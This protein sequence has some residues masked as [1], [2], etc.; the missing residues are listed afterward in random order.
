MKITIVI[1]FDRFDDRT[2]SSARCAELTI[3]LTFVVVVVFVVAAALWRCL[4]RSNRSKC[5]SSGPVA[6]STTSISLALKLSLPSDQDNGALTAV[7]LSDCAI[8]GS[9]G[10]GGASKAKHEYPTK[11]SFDDDRQHIPT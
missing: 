4:T 1:L 8:G 7:A 9:G 2:D 10:N 3:G 5:A 6:T 11:T